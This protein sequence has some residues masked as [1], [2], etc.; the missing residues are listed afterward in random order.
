MTGPDPAQLDAADPLAS[1]RE[2][3]VVADPALIYLDGNSLGRLPRDTITVLDDAVRRQWGAGLVSSWNEW[4][5]LPTSLGDDLAPLLGVSPGEVLVT[6][7]TS[8]NLFKLASAALADGRGTDI[9]TDDANFPSD[10]YVLDAVA[11]SAGGRLRTVAGDAITGVTAD[12]VAGATD[13][14]VA[15]VS[16]SHVSFRSGAV[17]DLTDITATAHAAG[18]LALW[19]LSHSVGALPIDLHAARV[20]LAVGCTYKYLNAG[21]GAPAFLFVRSD[22]QQRL[23]SP[24]RGWFGHEAMFE[25]APEYRPAPDIRRFG[26]GT[27]PVVSMLGIG[28]GVAITRR[29][30]IDEIRSKSLALTDMVVARV[31]ASLAAQGVRLGSP[32]DPGRRGGHVA[33]RHAA[34]FQITQAL[35]AAGVVVDFRTPDVIRIA[36]AALYTTYTEVARA[37]DA[38]EQIVS[39]GEHEAYPAEPAGVT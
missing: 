13:D 18:A 5:D 35:A 9:V 16:L 10:R 8:V 7:Q 19:D 26:S 14:T 31:D 1:F 38:L 32:R 25:F 30:G 17:A 11:R 23:E 4:I 6:D 33:L 24:I 15:L 3:F 39:S 2:A 27:P 12:E 34:A 20:D 21:P 36:P 37:L 22:L 29:A 28:P